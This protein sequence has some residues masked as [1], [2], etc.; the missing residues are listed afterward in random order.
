[1]GISCMS[2]CS[3]NYGNKPA[4]PPSPNPKRWELIGAHQYPAGYV[5][6]VKY[7]D[8]TN[9]EGIKCMVY[10]GSFPGFDNI[11]SLDPHFTPD[12]MSPVARFRP[13]REGLEMA[14]ELAQHGLDKKRGQL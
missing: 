4:P 8:A 11:T 3:T 12:A 14:H 2:R 1:M 13:D 10:R 9:F 7:L 5:L 6:V